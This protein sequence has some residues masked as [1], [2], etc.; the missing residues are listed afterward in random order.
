MSEARSKLRE[1]LI[2]N[3]PDKQGFEHMQL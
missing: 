3:V 1:S 2:A